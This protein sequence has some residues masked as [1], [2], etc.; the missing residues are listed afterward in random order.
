MVN[1]FHLS[2]FVITGLLDVSITEM[3][4]QFRYFKS[5]KNYKDSGF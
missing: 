4:A 3:A 5:E 1:G 2:Y